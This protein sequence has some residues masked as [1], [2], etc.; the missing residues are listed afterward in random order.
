MADANAVEK[1]KEK[2]KE[3]DPSQRSI[4]EFMKAKTSALPDH[5]GEKVHASCC[6]HA[7]KAEQKGVGQDGPDEKHKYHCCKCQRYFDTHPGSVFTGRRATELRASEKTNGG[8]MDWTSC[9]F[10]CGACNA[11]LGRVN[12]VKSHMNEALLRGWANMTPAEMA[13]VFVSAE[14]LEGQKLL[15]HIAHHVQLVHEMSNEVQ[16]GT[17]GGFYPLSFYKYAL[18]RESSLRG[19]GCSSV[20]S[21]C[22]LKATKSKC[23]GAAYGLRCVCN[24]SALCVHVCLN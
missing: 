12:H 1:E 13:K 21:Q 19:K 16:D 2:E 15:D 5:D 3:H 14:N 20:R 11:L 17:E 8:K 18:R 7:P 9:T 4:K 6:G 10:R 23:I 24:P 22:T